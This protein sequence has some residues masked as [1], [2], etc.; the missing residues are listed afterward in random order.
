MAEEK[1]G[2]FRQFLRKFGKKPS[3][4]EGLIYQVSQYKAF[5]GERQKTLDLAVEQ[6]LLEYAESL[7]AQRSGSAKESMR[8]VALYYQYSGNS[9]LADGAYRIRERAISQTRKVFK[10]NDFQGVDPETIHRLV[11]IGIVNV[12]QMLEA[13]KTLL[14]RQILAEETG[15]SLSS[16]I[17]LVKLS[18]LSRLAGV[19]NIRARL[20]YE[21]GVDTP[22]AIAQ[23]EP[24]ALHLM[25]V[26][27]VERTGF[28][29]IPPLPKEV[30]ST[31]EAAKRLP[32]I[33][34]YS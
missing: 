3:V 27:Y 22:E 12:E 28:K 17:E 18:D 26:A 14:L 25:L 7:E 24:E 6:D 10:L 31:V 32:K 13:G 1:F 33:V 21:A 29:G 5:L 20:Y 34:D 23:W 15:I 16:I 30:L 19:K 11:A 4:V 8:G 9:V 2:G